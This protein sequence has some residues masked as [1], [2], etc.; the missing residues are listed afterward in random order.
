MASAAI[1]L[2]IA[3]Q[4]LERHPDLDKK[5]LFRG[6]LYPDVGINSIELHYPKSF[7][8]CD[9]AIGVYDKVDLY[10]FLLSNNV[11]NS[12]E[13]GWFLHLVTD[14]LF[15]LECFTEEYLL[16]KTCNKFCQELYHAYDCLDSYLFTK[17]HI[18]KEDYEAY[19]SE[20]YPGIPYEE[21]ILS[22]EMVDAFI[23]RVSSIDLEK[24]IEK[25]KLAQENVKP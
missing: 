23:D 24:Y 16:S 19:S 25:I 5:D 15:F 6:T 17:Y 2:A 8:I 20:Y 3:K 9:F 4:Y 11:F 13:V 1:H 7:V 21:C 10:A 18:V 22:K 14:Y 12:F